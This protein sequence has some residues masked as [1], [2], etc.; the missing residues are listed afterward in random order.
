MLVA[1]PHDGV[2][3]NRQLVNITH[4]VTSSLGTSGF[5]GTVAEQPIVRVTVIDADTAGVFVRPA[6][7]GVVVTDTQPSYYDMVLTMQPAGPV[8][9]AIANDGQTIQSSN[10]SRFTAAALRHHAVGCGPRRGQS[11]SRG[12]V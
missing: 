4:R 6:P 7:G 9:V 8:T 12:A 5:F 11:G 2:V 10:D 1:A 3:E